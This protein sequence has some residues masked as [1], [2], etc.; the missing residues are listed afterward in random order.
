MVREEDLRELLLQSGDETSHPAVV[1]SSVNAVVS[2]LQLSP[3][4]FFTSALIFIEIPQRT[5]KDSVSGLVNIIDPRPQY[6]LIKLETKLKKFTP[7]VRY[8]LI[9]FPNCTK[10]AEYPQISL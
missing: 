3:I 6:I 1:R 5:N 10:E 4:N 7:Q 9:K 8:I 2:N